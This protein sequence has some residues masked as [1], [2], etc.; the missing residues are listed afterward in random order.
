MHYMIQYDI[1]VKRI[2]LIILNRHIIY[3][4]FIT[5]NIINSN[6]I[7]K[8]KC[9]VPLSVTALSRKYFNVFYS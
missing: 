2:Y 7:V 1:Y 3:E 5:I 6:M 8:D 9:F 4:D